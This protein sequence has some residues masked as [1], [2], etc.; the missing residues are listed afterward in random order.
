MMRARKAVDETELQ[1]I[2]KIFDEETEGGKRHTWFEIREE[3]VAFLDQ[4]LL[5]SKHDWVLCRD[6]QEVA[7]AIKN[8]VVRGA[9][10]IGIASALGVW[11]G[12]K[13]R[14]KKG[15]KVGEKEFNEIKNNLLNTRPTAYNLKSA[16]DKMWGDFKK[17]EGQPEIADIMLRKAKEIWF[18]DFVSCYLIGKNGSE[19]I[20][21]G[22]FVITICNTGSLATGGWGTALS[23]IK[24]AWREGKKFG[25]IVLETRPFLQGARLT[26]WELI[27]EK[28]PFKLIVDSASAFVISKIISNTSKDACILTGADRI[29]KDGTTSNKIGTLM[30]AIVGKY[31]SIP[32]YV[33][34]PRT[35]I[36]NMSDT[37]P[38]E[39]RD[40]SELKNISGV[41][42]TPNE[43]ETLNFVFDITPPHL[44]SAIITEDGIFRYP[45]SF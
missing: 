34:A 35:S 13:K 32:L 7:W 8:M 22:G 18:Y 30:L 27:R 6:D 9:P 24:Y 23:A 2:K 21:D 26:T 5:P 19:V 42:I 16:L 10:A 36:D 29:L 39:Q 17:H 3:G 31:F 38:I 33:L 4:R 41:N 25:V 20:P 12:I 11:L 15:E 1:N 37:I 45:Y 40:D 43:T 44:I 14:E 28:I